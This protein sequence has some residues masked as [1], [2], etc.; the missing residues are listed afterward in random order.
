MLEERV[1]EWVR[2]RLGGGA[3]NPRERALRLLEEACELAQAEG[4]PEDLAAK[5]VAHVYSRPPGESRQEAGGVAV[6]LMGWCASTGHRLED[7]A[8]A[9]LERIERRPPVEIQG[10]ETRKRDLTLAAPRK[11]QPFEYD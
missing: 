8:V 5:Q 10:S 6:T 4:V 9:E 2:T 3:M 7:L 1:A 11:H